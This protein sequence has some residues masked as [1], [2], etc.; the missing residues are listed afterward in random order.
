MGEWK[1]SPPVHFLVIVLS[2]ASF[3]FAIAAEWRPS[4]G[5]LIRDEATIKTYCVYDVASAYGAFA[6][7]FLLS[8]QS[9]LMGITRCM[10]FGRHPL[11][12]G[13]DR[14]WTVIY[15]ISSWFTF[16]AAVIC[17]ISGT[18]KNGYHTI[19]R[20]LVFAD[21]LSCDVLRKGTFIFGAVCV[22][23]TMLLNIYYYIYFSR[24]VA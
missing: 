12:S 4:T 21:D 24:A 5:T 15:F 6:L 20:D 23:V 18:R 10:C 7:L 1:G 14:D 16:G 19:Y 13:G 17:L 22:V 3:V 9:L 8:S 11:S 2:L